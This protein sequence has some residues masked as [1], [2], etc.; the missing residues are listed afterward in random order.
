[1]RD[2]L[3]TA[4][5]T[6]TEPFE[7][8][9]PSGETGNENTAPVSL[10]V[11][12]LLNAQQMTTWDDVVKAAQSAA[13]ASNTK[14]A[15]ADPTS[16]VGPKAAYYFNGISASAVGQDV[17]VTFSLGAWSDAYASKFISGVNGQAD[18][19]ATA[20]RVKDSNLDCVFMATASIDELICGLDGT[21]VRIDAPH[22]PKVLSDTANLNISKMA[23][24]MMSTRQMLNPTGKPHP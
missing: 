21:V 18:S 8:S 12:P 7:G 19:K 4:P 13:E 2:P 17:T 3:A 23:R 1:M 14:V 5:T 11:N 15:I 24:T 10:N 20:T 22:D 6:A 9:L 16:V